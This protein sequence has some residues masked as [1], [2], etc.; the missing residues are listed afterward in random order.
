[1]QHGQQII[2]LHGERYIS[3]PLSREFSPSFEGESG[4]S[5]ETQL[6]MMINN[7]GAFLLYIFLPSQATHPPP[8]P[9]KNT[10]GPS[11]SGTSLFGPFMTFPSISNSTSSNSPHW[12]NS[13]GSSV[14]SRTAR[15]NSG[16]RAEPMTDRPTTT[17]SYPTASSFFIW[18]V[19]LIPPPAMV[20]IGPPDPGKRPGGYDNYYHRRHHHHHCYISRTKKE[21]AD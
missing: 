3:L 10:S 4:G 14:L 19:V 6:T 11:E 16:A 18:S 20:T 9:H 15:M 13:A 8:P 21:N 12:L 5:W 7:K 2:L 1:M 17:P